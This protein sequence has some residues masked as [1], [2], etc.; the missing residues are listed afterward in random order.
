VVQP[1]GTV[2][3][4]ADNIAETGLLSYRSTDGGTSWGPT[5]EITPIQWHVVAGGL[6]AGTLPSAGIDAS[7][8]VYVA[9]PD[10]R[11]RPRCASND[12]LFSRSA[13][14][15]HWSAPTRVP[16]DSVGSSADHFIPGLG[17]DPATS[18]ADAHLG[19]T[20][21]SYPRADCA[22]TTCRLDVG[23]I[24]SPDAGTTWSTP[25]RLNELSMQLAWLADTS[26]GRMVGDYISTSFSNGK[27][28]GIFA[29]A[30]PPD[31]GFHES[32]FAVVANV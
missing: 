17:V 9:W 12:I 3:V 2:V 23:F 29:S 4:P 26:Q 30:T 20:Y 15:L 7:G 1:D 28:V 13:D 11:F 8:T 31:P 27:A 14:G 19:L 5:T 6:R 18:G 10:C 22:P 21:Y 16:I 25:R 32:M 24:S